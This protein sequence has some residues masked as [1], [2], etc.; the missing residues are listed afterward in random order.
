MICLDEGYGGKQN[1]HPAGRVPGH[2]FAGALMQDDGLGA[3][4]T[5][6]WLSSPVGFR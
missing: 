4:D 3:P 6:R 1:P 2:Y 5:P